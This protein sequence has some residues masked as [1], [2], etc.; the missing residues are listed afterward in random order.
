MIISINGRD[1]I[2]WILDET[3]EIEN[4]LHNTEKWIGASATEDNLTGYQCISGNN[5]FGAEVLLLDIANTP[6]EAGKTKFDLH[7]VVPVAVSVATAYLLRIV[8][9]S[10]TF[11]AAITARQYTTVPFMGTGLGSNISGAA[12]EVICKRIP[13]G[14]KVWAQIKNATNLA[15]M[16]FL[17]GIH[18]YTV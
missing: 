8:W 15:T 18:E 3:I 10:G 11:A 17:I 9:G 14:Y 1:I 2:Q 5:A 7:R 6:I 4:H 16:N 13:A 12:S